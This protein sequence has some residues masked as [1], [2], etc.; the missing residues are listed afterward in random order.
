LTPEMTKFISEEV[1]LLEGIINE[2]VE[3]GIKDA[4]RRHMV[5]FK[6]FAES[7]NQE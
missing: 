6:H 2:M 1:F 7:Y 4:H 3:K 5:A